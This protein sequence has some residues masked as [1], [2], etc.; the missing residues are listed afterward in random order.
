MRLPPMPLADDLFLVMH[1]DRTGRPRLHPRA[2]GLG[3]G[4]ALLGELMLFRRLTITDGRL[5]VVS[6]Q[7]PRDVVVHAV[8]DQVIAER[9]PHAVRTWLVFFAQA[10]TEQVAR[11]LERAG[12]VTRVEP[13]WPHR[14]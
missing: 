13:H 12:Y 11:R 6:D 9:Q 4:G 8:L 3:L 14:G 1:D 2:V 7:P 10:A 5:V